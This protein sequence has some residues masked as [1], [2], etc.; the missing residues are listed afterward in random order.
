MSRM[1]LGEESSPDGLDIGNL[2]G[3]DESLKLLG[4]QV[5][6]HQRC[7]VA[8]FCS[9]QTYGDLD[10]VIGQDEGGVGG[11]ELGG[12]HCELLVKSLI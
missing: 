4:L 10:A 7:A 1:Y 5:F 6:F 9:I 8:E 11:S 2:G 3:G 12:R